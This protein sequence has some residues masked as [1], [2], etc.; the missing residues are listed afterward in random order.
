MKL[1]S[2]VLDFGIQ[3]SLLLHCILGLKIK[4]LR[5]GVMLDFQ[6]ILAV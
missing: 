6:M 3:Y 1:E 2:N 4:N 5:V